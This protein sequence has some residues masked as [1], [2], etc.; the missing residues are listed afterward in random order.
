[1]KDLLPKDLEELDLPSHEVVGLQK[2]RLGGV[3]LRVAAVSLCRYLSQ[4]L[5]IGALELNFVREVV[6]VRVGAV[7]SYHFCQVEPPHF[8]EKGDSLLRSSGDRPRRDVVSDGSPPLLRVDLDLGGGA[9]AN[10]EGAARQDI[11]IA[12]PFLSK[13]DQSRRLSHNLR[14]PR[15]VSVDEVVRCLFDL[16]KTLAFRKE[17]KQSFKL[18][19]RNA[20]FETISVCYVSQLF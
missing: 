6:G 10:I 16:P 14:D 12:E 13:T 17:G 19:L 15:P 3:E 9:H 7:L 4:L 8:V 20:G 2:K 18:V 5:E 1:M 11:H